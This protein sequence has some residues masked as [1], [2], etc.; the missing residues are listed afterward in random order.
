MF[1]KFKPFEAPGSYRW[2][3]PDTKREFIEKDKPTLISRIKEYRRQNNLDEIEHIGFI[4]ESYWCTLPENAGKCVQVERSPRGT[5]G[6]IKGGVALLKTM[7][8]RSFAHQNVADERAKQ[9]STCKFNVFPDKGGFIEWSNK[10]AEA[11]TSSRKS[12][13]HDELGECSVCTCP[14]RAKVFYNESIEI[15][16]AWEKPMAEVN[17][18]QLKVRKN[19]NA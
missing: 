4:L 18:W 8:Y 6:Y 16:P 17:C 14:L 3:D 5:W 15:E 10:L 2:K 19:T 12:K 1:L 9:C 7:L 11:S 13:Y